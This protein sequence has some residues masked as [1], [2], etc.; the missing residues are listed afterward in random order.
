MPLPY[1]GYPIYVLSD[2]TGLTEW[3]DYIPVQQEQGGRA[4]SYDLAGYLMGEAVADTTGLTAWVDYIPV[5]AV[6][7]RTIP[8][9]VGANGYIPYYEV[10][11]GILSNFVVTPAAGGTT[12]SISVNVNSDEGTVYFVVVPSGSAAP[13]EAQIEAGTDG[14]DVAA[15][16]SGSAA[17]TAIDTYVVGPLG[18]TAETDYVA[19]AVHED[20]TPAYSNIVSDDFTTLEAPANPNAAIHDLFASGEEGLWYSF[21]VLPS[22]NLSSTATGAGTTATTPT[23]T[24]V[25]VNR[26]VDGGD[27]AK[28]ITQGGSEI[29]SDWINNSFETFT[30]NGDGSF[31]A[32]RATSGGN[33]QCWTD[34]AVTLGT[35]V[36]E[37]YR[38]S[39]EVKDTVGGPGSFGFASTTNG[40]STRLNIPANIVNWTEI[41]GWIYVT[42]AQATTGDVSF[43]MASSGSI[44]FRNMKIRRVLG[45]NARAPAGTVLTA[46]DDGS[47]NYY[48]AFDGSTDR[49][50]TMGT[51]ASGIEGNLDLSGDNDLFICASLY[52]DQNAA[53]SVFLKHGTTTVLTAKAPDFTA[54]DE[55]SIG[56]GTDTLVAQSATTPEK[57]VVSYLRTANGTVTLRVNGT[58]VDTGTAGASA[59][60]NAVLYI[61]S[62]GTPD[63][64]FSGGI[65]DLV[66][67]NAATSL[68]QVQACEARLAEL[69]GITL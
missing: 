4:M 61:G 43:L 27:P 5:Y 1:N 40:R 13:S 67:R 22:S 41:V 48:A 64:Y 47:G 2:V 51:G 9:Y 12:A 69:A 30:N 59:L 31:T 53:D 56:D 44:T 36:A 34:A 16:W 33:Q 15:T 62:T 26:K 49:L 18:L 23:N 17:V 29:L 66:V 38:I 24:L 19:Y 46:T 32:A 10:V 65:Y 60:E 21:S 20:T 54:G 57:I 37:V 58:Q 52:R 8:W 35:A 63:T 25:T 7:S 6:S 55:F 68:A 11:S 39:V 50:Y 14:N 45:V 3:V 42:T 28:I